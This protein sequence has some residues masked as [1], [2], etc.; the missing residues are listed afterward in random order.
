MIAPEDN[1]P[2]WVS[3]IPNS[4]MIGVVNGPTNNLSAWCSSINKKKTP[5]TNQRYLP[6][7]IKAPNVFKDWNKNQ[8]IQKDKLVN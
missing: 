8:Y 5:T 2:I 1:R 6:V 7:F 4:S 3:L